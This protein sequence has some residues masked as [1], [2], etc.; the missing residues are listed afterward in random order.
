[1]TAVVHLDLPFGAL[2][3]VADDEALLRVDF[4]PVSARVR[5]SV[6]AEKILGQT[7][8]A[9]TAYAAGETALSLPALHPLGTAF[10]QQVWQA[11]LDIPFGETRS[12]GQIAAQLGKSS[13]SRAVGM[14]CGRNPIAVLIPCHRVV[15]STG[16]LTGYAGG[17]AF[18]QAL[19]R[20]EGVVL[21]RS[22]HQTAPLF[23]P[24]TTTTRRFASQ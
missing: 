12:Y 10:Q 19:L 17:I 6:P 3:L 18:K 15:G 16:A 23:S 5:G 22:S 7:V 20:H 14:A 11:L 1:M 24:E 2:R 8:E 4:A 13:A 9:L 21:P